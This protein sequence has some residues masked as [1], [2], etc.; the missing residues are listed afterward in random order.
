MSS[1]IGVLFLVEREPSLRSLWQANH[2]VSPEQNIFSEIHLMQSFKSLQ[3]TLWFP[4]LDIQTRYVAASA[5]TDRQTH[6]HTERLPYPSHMRRGLKIISYSLANW[7]TGQSQL[8]LHCTCGVQYNNKHTLKA[9][10]D[11]SQTAHLFF[12]FLTHFSILKLDW[13]IKRHRHAIVLAGAVRT[14][15]YT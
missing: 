2:A 13:S 11:G 5:V 10:W 6:T 15:S 4:T 14:L 12:E 3:G 7:I 9:L 1:T 8:I